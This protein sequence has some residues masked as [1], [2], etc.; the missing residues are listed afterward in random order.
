MATPEAQLRSE[1]LRGTNG[2][3]VFGKHWSVN[4]WTELLKKCCGL[5]LEE[6]ALLGSIVE[7]DPSGTALMSLK[8]KFKWLGL[9]PKPSPAKRDLLEKAALEFHDHS[10]P[11]E[12]PA[13]N[14]KLAT[15]SD[16]LQVLLQEV[17][18]T[19]AEELTDAFTGLDEVGSLLSPCL[20]QLGTIDA[21]KHEKKHS[22]PSTQQRTEEVK[23]NQELLAKWPANL[24]LAKDI[25]AAKVGFGEIM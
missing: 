6:D 25:L 16:S 10:I 17:A 23:A 21:G 12:T 19:P 24:L 9:F 14:A 8:S 1:G 13:K 4:F 5:K 7:V 20:V 11:P 22:L 15:L 2:H 18:T 3:E